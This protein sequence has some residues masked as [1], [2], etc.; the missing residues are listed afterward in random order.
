MNG[1]SLNELNTTI[2]GQYEGVLKV[3]EKVDGKVL[4]NSI[5]DLHFLKGKSKADKIKTIKEN[6]GVVN[7]NGDITFVNGAKV[8]MK[9]SSKGEF[10]LRMPMAN[11][12]PFYLKLNSK[13]ISIDHA[14]LLHDLYSVRINDTDLTKS[15]R[16]NELEPSL[17][18]KINN[19]LK[20]EVNLI[21]TKGDLT[22]KDVIDF[23]VWDGAKSI[24]SRIKLEGTGTEGGRQFIYGNPGLNGAIVNKGEVINK[25]NFTN[26]LTSDKRYSISFKPKKGQQSKASISINDKYLEYLLDNKILNTNAVVGE[27]NPTF[28]GFTT[29]YLNSN[30]IEKSKVSPKFDSKVDGDSDDLVSRIVGSNTY[31]ASIKSGRLF[32]VNKN[33]ESLHTRIMSNAELVSSVVKDNKI[34]DQFE[35]ENNADDSFDLFQDRVLV[36]LTRYSAPTPNLKEKLEIKEVQKKKE[37]II[38]K[39]EVNVSDRLIQDLTIHLATAGLLRLDKQFEK[40]SKKGN[41]ALFEYLKNIADSNKEDIA[42]IIKKCQ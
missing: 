2:E 3:D 27:N 20:D 13:K 31:L 1:K 9:V 6:I 26:W 24:K 42:A 16:I 4:E 32:S 14:S 38:P 12:K 36:S 15:T 5:M 11:G 8:P 29:I 35:K 17:A 7:D 25:E 22:I 23:L 39:D 19:V 10:Y 41:K 34:I 40:T 21:G 30:G 18:S 37:K 28:Q 33:I